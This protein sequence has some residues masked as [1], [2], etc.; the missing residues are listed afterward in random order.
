MESVIGFGEVAIAIFTSF[1]VALTLEWIGLV[2]LMR[3]MPAR[4]AEAE[5]VDAA[6]RRKVVGLSLVPRGRKNAA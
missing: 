6:S 3:L 1:A 2:G 4:E 5:T